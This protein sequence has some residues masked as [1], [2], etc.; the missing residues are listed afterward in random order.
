MAP[1]PSTILKV[2]SRVRGTAPVSSCRFSCVFTPFHIFRSTRPLFLIVMAPDSTNKR[3]SDGTGEMSKFKRP[4]LLYEENMH[5]QGVSIWME[6][7]TMITPEQDIPSDQLYNLL[8]AVIRN[9]TELDHSESLRAL[10]FG[11]NDDELKNFVE[12]H[13]GVKSDLQEGWKTKSFH[14]I[15]HSSA[16]NSCSTSRSAS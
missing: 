5:Y 15:R 10:T 14:K 6:R 7:K 4:P 12:C 2:C 3:G 16:L 9:E 1:V 13:P 11:K 8:S